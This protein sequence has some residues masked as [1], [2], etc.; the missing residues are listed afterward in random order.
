MESLRKLKKKHA[1]QKDIE[2]PHNLRSKNVWWRDES[3]ELKTYQVELSCE[4]FLAS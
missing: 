3:D 4:Y 2:N 1:I